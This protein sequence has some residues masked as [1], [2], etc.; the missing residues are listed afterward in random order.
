MTGQSAVLRPDELR[1]TALGTGRPFSRLAQ[2]NSGWLVEL[3]NG[4]VFVFDF[5]HGSFQRFAALEIPMSRITALFA[6]HLHTD[7]V[8]DFAAYWICARVGGRLEPLSC[9]GPTGRR[10]ELGFAHFARHQLL[11]YA[12]DIASRNGPLPAEG[13]GA[14]VHEFRWD[15]REVVYDRAGVRISTFPAVHVH[16]GAVG[17]RLDWND[18]SVVYSGDTA[19]NRFLVEA[20]QGVDVLVH[21]TVNGAGPS[22]G[23]GAYVHTGPADLGRILSMTQPRLAVAF[24]FNNDVG[25]RQRVSDGIRRSYDGG[26][27]LAEDLSTIHVSS[28]GIAVRPATVSPYSWPN[29]EGRRPYSGSRGDGLPELAPWLREARL[30]FPPE[31]P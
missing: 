21:E 15:A 30:F 22:G 20:S 25:T 23:P 19:P 2:A 12:W 4:D 9:Y 8:G 1:I 28:S 7:H 11:S 17:L 5:G 3:G 31:E 6:T 14:D 10:P 18:R 29:T 13:A 16:D 27:L 24:H 26:L